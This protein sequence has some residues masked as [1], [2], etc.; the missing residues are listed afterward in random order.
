M[1]SPNFLVSKG[2][3]RLRQEP[4]ALHRRRPREKLERH[5]SVEMSGTK[6]LNRWCPIQEDVEAY[7]R[8]TL[9]KVLSPVFALI[10]HTR[11]YHGFAVSGFVVRRML[12]R[13]VYACDY[14]R[15]KRKSARSARVHLRSFA[16]LFCP[17]RFLCETSH[18][19]YFL[20][21]QPR[22]IYTVG[23]TLCWRKFF[24]RSAS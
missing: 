7:F 18:S 4:G 11:H 16:V 23:V 13:L 17:I 14:A 22:S 10:G 3:T 21:H 1:A 12:I 19:S 5:C 24:V 9:P 6:T 20:G 8:E 15:R 2:Q